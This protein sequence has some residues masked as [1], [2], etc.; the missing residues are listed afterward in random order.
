MYRCSKFSTTTGRL[1]CA[2]SAIS[3][4]VGRLRGRLSIELF[5]HCCRGV[6]LARGKILILRRTQGV[7]GTRTGVLSS[8]GS[9]R[10]VR[11]R[12]QLSVSDSIY[13]EC[14]G[15]SFLHFRRR[16]PRVGIRVARGNARR[17]FSGLQGGRASLIFALSERVCSSSFVV[18]TR[19]R[20]RMR[21]VMTTSGPITNYS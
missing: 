14:F 21:F 10:D 8:L 3:S 1:K 6:G 18:Y 17:V 15:G 16:C 12:V 13:D 7:L 11:N 9:T 20:R 2:R 19:R 5:S 4:R